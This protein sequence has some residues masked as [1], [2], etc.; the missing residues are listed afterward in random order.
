MKKYCLL[1][2]EFFNTC[3]AEATTY[4]FHFILVIFMDL[5][6]Y[7]CSLASVDFIFDYV[8][9]I[10]PWQ[11]DEFMF[12]IAFMLAID[13]LHMTFISESFWNFSGDIRTGKLDFVLIKPMNSLFS[14][15]FRFIRPA[16]ALNAI[17]PWGALFY[18]GNGAGIELWG[19]LLL[20]PLVLTSLS[21]LVM[22]E[23][24][25][26]MLMF[27]TVESFGIN[28]LR[29]QFQQLSRWPDFVYRYFA[30]KAFTVF[31]PILLVGSAPVHFLL[32]ASEW[33]YLLWIA[34][35]IGASAFA[36]KI[37]WQLG[38]KKYESASS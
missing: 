30:R 28:F 13:H 34:V 14:I 38:L 29:I 17:F 12:F 22:L 32:D 11:R 31:F 21:L 37:F 10:G 8:K 1:Y 5:L 27:W 16:T 3:L 26:S 36:I 19:Y 35:A 20:P 23:I 6:F 25:I 18:F 9:V 33:D 7:A 2:R 24:L 4:R 15:F